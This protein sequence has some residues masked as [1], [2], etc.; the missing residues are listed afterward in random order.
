M[1]LWK[2]KRNLF[3]Q[4]KLERGVSNKIKTGV[5]PK[6]PYGTIGNVYSDKLNIFDKLNNYKYTSLSPPPSTTRGSV[7]AAYGTPNY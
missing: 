6:L 2:K 3:W 5:Q 4:F 1:Q 7:A